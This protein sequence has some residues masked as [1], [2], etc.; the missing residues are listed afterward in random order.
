MSFKE[1]STQVSFPDEEKKILE[2]W[3]KEQVFEKSVEMRSEDKLYSFYDGPPFATGLPHYGHLLAGIIKDIIPRYW[4][5][6]GYRVERRFGWDCHGLPVEYEIDKKLDI[7]GRKG[8]EEFGIANY[9]DEC[10]SIVQRYTAEWRQTVERIGRW[11]DFDNDY[12]TMNPDFME[13]VWWV[14]KQLWEKDLVYRGYKVLPYSTAVA[15]P[16]SNFE[17]SSNYKDLQDPSITVVF[18]AI[19]EENTSFLAWTT[20]PWTLPSNLALCV[21]PE[22]EYVKIKTDKHDDFLIMAKERLK[23]YFP[24]NK[25]FEII[26]TYEGKDLEGKEYE[27]LFPYFAEKREEGAFKVLVGDHVTI[28]DGTGIVH[29]APAFGEEDFNICQKYDIPLV[30]PI[31][32]DG[33]FVEPVSDFLGEH[34]KAADKNIIKHLKD[35]KLLYKQDTIQH[36][37]PVCWRSD[38]PLIYRVISTWFVK[39]EEIKERIIANNKKTNWIPE[40]LRDGRFGNWLEGARDWAISRNRF[41]GNPIP[42]WMNEETGETLCVGSIAELEKLTGKKIDDIHRQYIDDLEIPSPTGKKPL[43]RVPEVLDCWFESGSMPY[44]QA[45]Y[46]FENKEKFEKSFPADFIAEGLDQTRGWFYTLSILGTALFDS[47]PFKNVIVNGILLAEDGNKM[48]KRLKNYPDPNYVLDEYGADALRLY[49]I[50]SPAVRAE[51]LRFSEAGVKEIVRRV[52]LKTWNAYSFFCNYAVIDKWQPSDKK[53]E[54]TNL[55]DKWIISRMQSLLKRIEEE[56]AAY[57]LYNVVPAILDFVEDLTNTYIRF[58]RKR[59]WEQGQSDDKEA[60][61]Q[62][63]YDVLLNLSKVMAPFT[64]FQAEI[65][66]QNLSQHNT[67]NKESVHL[68][69]FP[70][71]QNES[72][73]S[74]LETSVGIMQQVLVMVRNLREKAKVKVKIPLKRMTIIHRTA[75]FLENVKELEGYMKEELNI[76]DID[77]SQ[78]EEKYVELQAKANGRVLGKK[79]GKKFGVINKK[80]QQLSTEELFKLESGKEIEI[81]GEKITSEGVNVHRTP[82]PGHDHVA[83]NIHITVEIDA[84]VD[85]DQMLEGLAREI[86][87]RVQKL[88]KTA[89]LK[90]DDN[91]HIEYSAE[92]DLQ[93]AIDSHPDYIQEQTL[94]TSLKQSDKPQGDTSEE[95]TIDKQKLVLAIKVA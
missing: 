55:L 89:D 20:T 43:K 8:V 11:V 22:I 77:Y 7:K 81:E 1:V 86:V 52:I 14:F 42:L 23:A 84:T 33:Q 2:F 13:S 68:E 75:E 48:S 67:D 63:L 92:K 35:Q 57:R 71:A 26:E 30:M 19:G 21:G 45:H 5:M 37:V 50:Q 12:K 31:D 66:Y 29:T 70:T 76:R 94:A 40:H 74:S 64:P 9:N 91:I 59:F 87:N 82:Q 38:T 95:Y 3:K 58:N 17:A 36:R 15:T 80:I 93:K 44:A 85:E 4:T 72:I 54:T 73:L 90:L 41:W 18:K 60:A 25:G 79:L 27:P 28:E 10:K 49:M 83:S 78:E 62:T 61:Y 53:V 46:P 69:D 56:M 24:K 47:I 51:D 6:K 65:I 39:V 34:V 16:L 88:R 32:D